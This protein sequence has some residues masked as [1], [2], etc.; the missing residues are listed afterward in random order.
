MAAQ[1]SLIVL[2]GPD[3]VGKS[4]LIKALCRKLKGLSINCRHYSFPG[5]DPGSLGELV[6]R[7]HHDSDALGIDQVSPLALQATHIAAHLDAIEREFKPRIQEG[8]NIVLDRFWWSTF[9]YGVDQGV[10]SDVLAKL[11]EAEKECWRPIVPLVT[12][13]IDRKRPWRQSEDTNEWQKLAR[14]YRKL[15]RREKHS[16]DVVFIQN[17]ESVDYE[18]AKIAEVVKKRR[19]NWLRRNSS[20]SL[21][22]GGEQLR[23]ASPAEA[24]GAEDVP[25]LHIPRFGE[26]KT[27]KVF[28]TYWYF[29]HERQQVF[30]RRIDREPPPWTT[31]SIIRKHR[32]T[33]VYRASD[34]VSQYLIRRVLYEGKQEFQ[35]VFFRTLLFKIFNRISTWKL[36]VKELGP[37]VV[38]GFERRKYEE[39]L[40]RAQNRGQA[41]YNGA[42]IMPAAPGSK[43]KSKHSGHLLLLEKMIREDLPGRLEAADSL[44][45]AFEIL[46]SYPMMGDFLAYQYV[47]DLNY[48][49]CFDFSEMEFVVAGPGAVRGIEKCFSCIGDLSHQDIIRLVCDSQ[50]EQFD[51]RSLEFRN[52]WGRPLQLIDCQNLFCEVDKYSRVAHPEIEAGGGRR[53]IKQKFRSSGDVEVPWYPPKWGLNQRIEREVAK[54]ASHRESDS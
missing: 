42:Y 6:Y 21:Q 50:E 5:K 27:T 9:V 37:P 15:A 25:M 48:G 19:R 35:E 52:L 40:D 43:G 2:E 4:T 26:L 30:F 47:I 39:V 16:G 28:D 46:R 38:D 8:A 22:E 3:G 36:L 24:H 20:H 12:F 54:N 23:I 53:R 34:R 33:N 45:Q 41:I 13:L 49:S 32:F 1:G 51:R 18:A 44:K 11:I 10:S 7:L 17:T 14:G 31:D 29:A